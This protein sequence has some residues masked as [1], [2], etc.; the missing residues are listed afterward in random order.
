[1]TRSGRRPR[2]IMLTRFPRPGQVKTRIAAELGDDVAL[3]LHDRLARHTLR[4]LL[5]LQACREAVAEVRT[6][7]SFVHAGREW[8]GKGPTYRYQGEGSL[9]GKLHLAFAESFSRGDGH[10]VVVGSDCPRLR[11]RHLREALAALE[12]S[13]VVLGPAVDGGYY[14]IGIRHSAANT[15]LNTLFADVPWG[16]AEVFSQT[17]NLAANAELIV[18]LLETLPDVDIAADVAAAEEA[19]SCLT[20]ER[21]SSARVS[22]VIPALNEAPRIE[23]AVRSAVDGGA[24]EVIVADGGSS[25]ST[26]ATAAAAGAR[27]VDAMRG[28]ALQMNAGAAEASGEILCFLHAD[29]SLPPGFAKAAR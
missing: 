2:V 8:L 28:R 11:A 4:A 5:A 17:R 27:V 20:A 9:G 14:L 19:L 10:V 21:S 23:G 7:A 3:D 13:D 29:T 16:T 26:G 15:A 24:A 1:M 22:V 12:A 25:D 18:A 6:D